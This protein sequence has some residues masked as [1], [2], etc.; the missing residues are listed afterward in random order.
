MKLPE[1]YFLFR[2][3]KQYVLYVG[4]AYPHKNL[5]RLL[6]AISTIHHLSSTIHLVLVGAEDFFY[7]KLKEKVEE[8]GLEDVVVFWGLAER[9]ELVNLY[10]NAIA[11]VF[12]SLM[13]G[14]G[15]PAVEAMANNCLVL[16]SDIPVFHEILGE[17]AVYF[18]PNDAEDLV[19]KL[20]SVLNEPT[21]YEDL[22]YKGFTQIKKYS[23][24]KMASQTLEVYE[25]VLK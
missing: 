19:A 16:A 15:L 12:P 24:E 2:R 20:Q 13:E 7:K 17:T 22:K 8:M 25:S 21:M 9:S 23:W 14:F 1:K 5:E 6:E 3:K 4:N 18:N 11:L 10:K